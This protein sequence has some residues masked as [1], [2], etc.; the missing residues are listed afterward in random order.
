MT[1]ELLFVTHLLINSSILLALFLAIIHCTIGCKSLLIW[2][3][4]SLTVYDLP[5][6]VSFNVVYR[7]ISFTYIHNTTL[8][9]IKKQTLQT[10]LCELD[11]YVILSLSL[12]HL[13]LQIVL[14]FLVTHIHDAEASPYFHQ[15]LIQG[16]GK[17]ALVLVEDYLVLAHL[18]HHMQHLPFHLLSSHRWVGELMR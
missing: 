18:T 5:K 9:N 6:I 8:V 15:F 4:K 17:D 3:P 2:T 11:F 14:D 7:P 16:E 12:S 1:S 13:F 10:N